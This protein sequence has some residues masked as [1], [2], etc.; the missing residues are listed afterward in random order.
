MRRG[1]NRTDNGRA[2][3]IAVDCS[4]CIAFVGAKFGAHEPAE[5]E[6]LDESDDGTL[7]MR[8]RQYAQS[9]L[10]QHAQ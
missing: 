9:Q 6:P 10:A 7:S 5:F 2:H 3:S 8:R 1:F 4:E